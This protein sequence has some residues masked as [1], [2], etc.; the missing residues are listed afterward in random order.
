[1]LK[2]LLA[3]LCC[4]LFICAAGCSTKVY[5]QPPAANNTVIERDRPVAVDR[6]APDVQNNIHVDRQ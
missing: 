1:M 4:G 3:S 2:S 6:T 5:N